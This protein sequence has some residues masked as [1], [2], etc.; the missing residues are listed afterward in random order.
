[1]SSLAAPIYRAVGKL[2]GEPL[3]SRLLVTLLETHA[4]WLAAS[5]MPVDQFGDLLGINELGRD[6]DACAEAPDV[7]DAASDPSV[8]TK[9]GGSAGGGREDPARAQKILTLREFLSLSRAEALSIL[10]EHPSLD[11]NAIIEMM[12]GG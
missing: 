11:V 2:C 1:M 4:N 8:R 10:N 5:G 9:G 12:M 7:R 3:L 6:E